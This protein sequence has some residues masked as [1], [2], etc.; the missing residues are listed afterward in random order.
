MR[1]KTAFNLPAHVK[2][3]PGEIFSKALSGNALVSIIK[4]LILSKRQ[5]TKDSTAQTALLAGWVTRRK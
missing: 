5:M 2:S 1:L 4:V 3:F